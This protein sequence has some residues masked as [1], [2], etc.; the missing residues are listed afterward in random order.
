MTHIPTVKR[1]IL[2]PI[3][4]A[5]PPQP[6]LADRILRSL[7]V[8]SW[9]VGDKKTGSGDMIGD[10]P[11]LREDGTFDEQHNSWYWSFWHSVDSFLGTDFCGM[12]DD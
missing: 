10:G 8:V 1:A 6:K 3:S 12:K 5:L 7:P 4:E 11:T 2:R 9:F